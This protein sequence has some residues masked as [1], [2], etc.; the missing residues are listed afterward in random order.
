MY[1]ECMP[2]RRKVSRR[3]PR[4]KK[5]LTY[6]H[7]KIAFLSLVVVLI[8]S[9]T[10]LV[11]E[12][13][14]LLNLMG[15]FG[16]FLAGMLYVS[17]F[18]ASA[19]FLALVLLAQEH[20]PILITLVASLGGLLSDIIIF[21]FIRDDLKEEILD[22]YHRVGGRVLT[23]IFRYKPISWTLPVIGAIILASPFPDEIGILLLGI[24]K[25]SKLKFIILSYIL[26]VIGIF[27]VVEFAYLLL[28]N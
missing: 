19:G 12:F 27:F 23:K 28:H 6:I 14:L 20:N 17:A 10:A 24:S 13:F 22:L 18:T 25:T 11:K 9:Q 8:L 4:K 3:Y 1:S 7:L 5:K 15:F 26:N 21:N 2:A 16:A